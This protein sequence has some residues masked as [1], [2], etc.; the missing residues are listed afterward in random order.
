MGWVSLS[1]D[2]FS[3]ANTLLEFIWPLLEGLSEF[4]YAIWQAAP[5][6]WAAGLAMLAALVLLAPKLGWLRL[7]GAFGFIPLFSAKGHPN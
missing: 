2:L 6:L 3:L 5:P 1:T 4:S 7:M